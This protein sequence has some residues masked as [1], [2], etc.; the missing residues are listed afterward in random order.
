MLNGSW[1]EGAIEYKIIPFNNGEMPGAHLPHLT[2]LASI[3]ALSAN[4]ATKY[5]WGYGIENP[6]GNVAHKHRK[7][8]E[9]VRVSAD[10]MRICFG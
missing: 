10:A 2:N 3:D 7:V 5:L 9:L 6:A 1:S 8:A 4:D